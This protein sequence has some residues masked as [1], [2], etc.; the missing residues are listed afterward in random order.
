MGLALASDSSG[1]VIDSSRSRNQPFTF[2]IGLGEVI[3]GWDQ[4]VMKMSLGQRGVL[5]VP[6]ALGYGASGAGGAIPPN[7][8]LK[9]DVEVLGIGDQ[10]S[11]NGSLE[12]SNDSSG[13]D[14]LIIMTIFSV[15]VLFVVLCRKISGGKSDGSCMESKHS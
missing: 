4:G 6:S 5:T 10:R 13:V 3:K 15:G 8:D 7:A 14:P 1:A 11:A 12:L 9:F 2:T